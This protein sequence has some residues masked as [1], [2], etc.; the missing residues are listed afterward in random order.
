MSGGSFGYAYSRVEIFV[1]ELCERI[2]NND[3]KDEY[4]Y[5]PDYSPE[6]ISKLSRIAD[7][8]AALAKKMKDVEWMY[9]G[10]IGEETFLERNK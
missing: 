3:T 10:D 9:S 5:S 2:E 4:G 8:A 1:E 7:E 6:V